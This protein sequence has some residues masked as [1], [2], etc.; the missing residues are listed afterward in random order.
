MALGH[1]DP[2]TPSRCEYVSTTPGTRNSKV[3]A[4]G[5]R[6]SCD[7]RCSV[8]GLSTARRIRFPYRRHQ[9]SNNNAV[10]RRGRA[11]G[12][13]RRQRTDRIA[14]AE[15]ANVGMGHSMNLAAAFGARDPSRHFC[16]GAA[17]LLGYQRVVQFAHVIAHQCDI[18]AS[19][20]ARLR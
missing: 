19:R 13:Y 14:V 18:A 3:T 10:C 4:P 8:G 5:E 6:K 15:Q 9:L 1:G 11:N 17:V 12:F 16:R 7:R 2:N 20:A